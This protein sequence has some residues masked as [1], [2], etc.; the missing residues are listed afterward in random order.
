[1][2]LDAHELAG[3]QRA[4]RVG[5]LGADH[6]GAG[7]GAE[8]GIGKGDLAV[9]R[10]LAAIGHHDHHVKGALGRELERAGLLLRA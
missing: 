8:R 2:Q 3:T 9:M 1:M 6:V 7:L 4:L 5:D 10:E